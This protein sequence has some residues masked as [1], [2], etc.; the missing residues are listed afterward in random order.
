MASVSLILLPGMDGTGQL[1]E[2]FISALAGEFEVKV[3]TYPASQP[4]GYTELEAVARKAI[5]KE[6]PYVILGESFSGPIAVS[7]GASAS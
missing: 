2:P 4:L 5:P 3:V 7:L 6:G 1:F